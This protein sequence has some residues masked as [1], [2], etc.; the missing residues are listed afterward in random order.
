MEVLVWSLINLSCCCI[1]TAG[2]AYE[3]I[4]FPL[5]E[6][7]QRDV[8]MDRTTKAFGPFAFFEIVSTI[9]LCTLADWAVPPAVLHLLCLFVSI[10]ALYHQFKMM[11]DGESMEMLET[12]RK[13]NILRTAIWV[14][15]YFSLVII[16]AL[17]IKL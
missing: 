11:D 7:L 13:A 16:I 17:N 5:I 2:L 15:R 10:I 8:L 3:L 9:V 1:V 4:S 12:I 14:C 6:D